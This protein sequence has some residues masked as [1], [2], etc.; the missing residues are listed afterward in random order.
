LFVGRKYTREQKTRNLGVTYY[1]REDFSASREGMSLGQLERH[2]EEDYV[3]EL[4]NSCYRERTNSKSHVAVVC[5][6]LHCLDVMIL[7]E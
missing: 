7:E 5:L 2:V 1:V 6:V 4:Q 3:V